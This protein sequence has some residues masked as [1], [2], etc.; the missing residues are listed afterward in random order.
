MPASGM[1]SLLEFYEKC[2]ND[3][4]TILLAGV[5]DQLLAKLK[6]FGILDLIGNEHVFSSLSFAIHSISAHDSLIE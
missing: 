1:Y 2:K 3:Q 4:T 5:N 6:K